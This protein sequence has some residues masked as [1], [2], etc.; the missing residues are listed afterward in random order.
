M[1]W[2][3]KSVTYSLDHF[4]CVEISLFY[5]VHESSYQVNDD[6]CNNGSQ[7]GRAAQGMQAFFDIGPG[8]K[9]PEVDK[10]LAKKVSSLAKSM[11]F[12]TSSTRHDDPAPFLKR[13]KGSL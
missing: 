6:F 10:A 11:F 4:P 8:K 3:D 13:K 12:S 2:L 9:G 5:P 7:N 1:I